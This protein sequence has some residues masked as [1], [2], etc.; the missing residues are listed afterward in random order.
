MIVIRLHGVC[1][2]KQSWRSKHYE[3][4]R[5]K[6]VPGSSSTAMNL[7][8]AVLQD[9]YKPLFLYRFVRFS[10]EMASWLYIVC[11]GAMRWFLFKLKEQII[12]APLI[13]RECECDVQKPSNP[14]SIYTIPC[15]Y[16]P[17]LLIFFSHCIKSVD[18]VDAVLCIMVR[19]AWRRQTAHQQQPHSNDD[20]QWIGS[21][22]ILPLSAG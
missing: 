14:Q 6:W 19:M 5:S 2:N 1:N 12:N 3:N 18:H 7:Q 17:P 9:I 13:N 15:I 4:I 11:V 22:L 16:I 20:I 21:C 8:Y 10:W